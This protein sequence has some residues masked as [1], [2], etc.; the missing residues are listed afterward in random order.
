MGGRGEPAGGAGLRRLPPLLLL[1]L[2]LLLLPLLLR[3][4]A[5]QEAA[6]RLLL[7]VACAR[8]GRY[9]FIHIAGTSP[10]H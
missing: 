10:S 8:P 9:I 2:L 6:L 3:P 5:E 7:G 1:L 4:R